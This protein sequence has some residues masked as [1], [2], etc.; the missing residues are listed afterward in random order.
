MGWRSRQNQEARFKALTEIGGLNGL[1]ILD[2]GCGLGCLYGYLKARGWNGEYQGFDFLKSMVDRAA[3]RFPDARFEQR[4]ILKSPPKE[5]WDFVFICGV[6]NH[7]VRDNWGWME[8]LVME[9]MNL[10]RKGLAFNV[11]SAEAGWPD[12]ELFYV[13]PKLLEDKVAAWS[14]GN[15]KI[16]KG[17]LPEDLTVYLYCP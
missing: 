10:A 14:G 16:V 3:H 1:A 13:N 6:L 4:D 12:P 9:G 11:L 15:Y 7:K 8:Q 2:V 5:K 17:Y